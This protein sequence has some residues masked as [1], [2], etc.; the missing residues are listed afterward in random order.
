MLC[1]RSEALIRNPIIHNNT[2]DKY[3]PFD[4]IKEIIMRKHSQPANI[5]G[6]SSNTFETPSNKQPTLP[7]ESYGIIKIHCI[8]INLYKVN[9]NQLIITL[10]DLSIM[11]NM[12]HPYP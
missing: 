5:F 6:T 9:Q 8:L 10:K 11:I 2:I 3:N 12:I 4:P 7:N 1:L